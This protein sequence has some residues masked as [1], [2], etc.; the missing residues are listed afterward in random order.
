MAGTLFTFGS[1]LDTA[2]TFSFLKDELFDSVI[3]VCTIAMRLDVAD[4]QERSTIVSHKLD[5]IDAA[6]QFVVHHLNFSYDRI[7][8]DK[9]I[10]EVSLEHCVGAI[11]L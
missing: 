7:F 4:C 1:G 8:W 5:A 2:K 6:S 11:E 10:F 3:F 9:F